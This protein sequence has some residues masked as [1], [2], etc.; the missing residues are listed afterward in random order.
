MKTYIY[1]LQDPIT[2]K[3]KYVGKTIRP[4]RRIYD[5]SLKA[6]FKNQKSKCVNWIKSLHKKQLTPIF[7]IIDEIEGDWQ[8]LEKYWISQFKTWGFDL[9]NH[10]EGG[11]GVSGWIWDKDRRQRQSFIMK[12]A[13]KKG[14]IKP[15]SL[16]GKNGKNH[17]SSKK[18]IDIK[19]NVIYY[20]VSEAAKENNIK[21][22]TLVMMLKGKNKN[23][24]NLRYL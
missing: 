22:S 9:T 24:T 8:W 19:T 20:S 2:N 5:Y 12:D 21:N 16:I 7:I 1:T 11:E 4:K 6:S 13:I 18:I 23:K 3:I 14:I 15:N 17:P 10:T